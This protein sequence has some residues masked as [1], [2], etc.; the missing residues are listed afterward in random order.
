MK[1]MPLTRG[2]YVSPHAYGD[3]KI[4]LSADTFP[5]PEERMAPLGLVISELVVNALK[6]GKGMISVSLRK[7][8]EQALI[9]VTDEGSGFPE[10]YP[11]PNGTGLGMRL[12]KTY[13]GYGAGAILVDRSAKTSTIQVQLKL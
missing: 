13:S 6:Y 11:Q 12:I 8:G 10:T 9:T 7:E 4:E 1:Q 3:R 5:L 2:V